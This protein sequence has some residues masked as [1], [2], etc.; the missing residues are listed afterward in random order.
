MRP[1]TSKQVNFW[2]RTH[3]EAA[4]V[5]LLVSQTQNILENRVADRMPDVSIRIIDGAAVRAA[6]EAFVEANRHDLDTTRA[7]RT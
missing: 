5:R 4:R 1:G 7:Q 6:L 3:E 2:F